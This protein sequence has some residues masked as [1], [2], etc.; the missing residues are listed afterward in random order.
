M[1]Y[2]KQA[3][4]VEDLTICTAFFMYLQLPGFDGK[5][6]H[7]LVDCGAQKCVR[8]Q[9]L[10]DREQSSVRISEKNSNYKVSEE[11]T[12]RSNIKS[13]YRRMKAIAATLLLAN[14]HYSITKM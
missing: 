11:A 3:V 1:E 9:Q 13:F 6:I 10:I 5:S 8:N 7:C 12:N 2:R 14:P 4:E